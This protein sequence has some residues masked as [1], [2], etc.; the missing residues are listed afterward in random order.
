MSIVLRSEPRSTSGESLDPADWR[1]LRTQGH[2]MLD[3]MFDYLENI[4][5]RPV[6]Q[7]IPDDVRRRFDAPVPTA[8]T[9]LAEVHE[10]FMRD[11]LPFA[12]G[13]VHPRFMGW[14]QGGGNPV[15]MLAEMLAAGL[16]A[17]L[18]GRD[19]MPIEVE[20]QIVRWIR[21]LFGFPEGASGLFV[22]GTSMANFIGVL[23]ARTAALGTGIRRSG[24][25]SDARK[26]TAYTSRAA[27]CCIAQAM[28][29]AGLGSEALR[30]V[31]TNDRHQIDLAALEHAI[32]QDRREGFVPFLVVGTAGTVD[33]ASAKRLQPYGRFSCA[34]RMQV[35]KSWRSVSSRAAL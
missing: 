33:A 35:S 19:H 26:L 34:N 16:N 13:N 17:N 6:W 18:G 3:D 29:L 5:D 7:P 32:A 15:G 25:A 24:L 31:A 30:V 27:H 1:D 9:D 23:V 12:G 22:T 11:I 28:D 4:R 2:R 8:P 10:S 21:A 14:V 20:R